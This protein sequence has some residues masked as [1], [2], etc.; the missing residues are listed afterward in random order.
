MDKC[1]QA[2]RLATL[3]VIS[4]EMEIPQE[5]TAECKNQL[6]TAKVPLLAEVGPIGK[7]QNKSNVKSETADNIKTVCA[8]SITI[9]K[10]D[11]CGGGVGT[12]DEIHKFTGTNGSPNLNTVAAN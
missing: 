4:P 12:S 1:K 8:D 7:M 6:D 2:F 11:Q 9:I 3:K 10:Q 5:V